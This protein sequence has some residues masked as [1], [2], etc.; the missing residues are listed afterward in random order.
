MA[1]SAMKTELMKMGCLE[2][3]PRALFL[4]LVFVCR[5]A[6]SGQRSALGVIPQLSFFGGT[7]SHWNWGLSI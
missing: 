3:W 1:N 4:H 7:I 6:D 5:C 2:Q